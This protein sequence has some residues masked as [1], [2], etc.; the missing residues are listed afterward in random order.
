MPRQYGKKT[1]LVLSSEFERKEKNP[2]WICQNTTGHNEVQIEKK[3]ER[4][5]KSQTVI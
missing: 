3:N 1:F 5:H 4:R 2:L